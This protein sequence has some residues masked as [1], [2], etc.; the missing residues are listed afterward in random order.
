MPPHCAVHVGD[1][2]GPIS[3]GTSVPPLAWTRSPAAAASFNIAQAALAATTF[4]V[5][6]W[7]S[8]QSSLVRHPT[9]AK[10]DAGEDC[11]RGEARAEGCRFSHG[12]SCGPLGAHDR[13]ERGRRAL[14]EYPRATTQIAG[15]E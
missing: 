7:V 12:R 11:H 6:G 2:A 3:F 15:V 13:P 1:E 5:G 9:W 10:M 14:V 8:G 4:V